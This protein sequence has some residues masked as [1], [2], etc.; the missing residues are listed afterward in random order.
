MELRRDVL[1]SL[2][3]FRKDSRLLI[4]LLILMGS[5]ALLG[6]LQAWPLAVLVD[7]VVGTPAENDW[8]QQVFSITFPNAPLARIVALAV[9]A[10]VLRLLQEFIGTARRLVNLQVQYNGR[11]RRVLAMRVNS[12]RRSQISN[13][14]LRF[15][16]LAAPRGSLDSRGSP[17]GNT[18]DRFSPAP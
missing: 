1:R 7:S 13:L 10:L 12:N 5:S 11:R 6:L 18:A 4:F 17:S 15:C 16:N 2:G 14:R 9:T 3:Y 8:M